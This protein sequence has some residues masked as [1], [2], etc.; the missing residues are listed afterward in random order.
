[1]LLLLVHRRWAQPLLASR[2]RSG[3]A[4]QV[5]ACRTPTRRTGS[6][7]T[8]FTA[9]CVVGARQ[10][11]Q[12]P[13]AK[14]AGSDVE[15]SSAAAAGVVPCAAERSADTGALTSLAGAA[16][17]PVAK[18]GS[19]VRRG[20]CWGPQRRPPCSPTTCSSAPPLWIRAQCAGC[21]QHVQFWRW[22]RAS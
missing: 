10:A 3:H 11:D 5:R 6:L 18:L 15:A 16:R 4:Q 21:G 2:F 7:I 17:R 12:L 20:A 22:A 1:M 14:F 9:L 19:T 8:L 13:A